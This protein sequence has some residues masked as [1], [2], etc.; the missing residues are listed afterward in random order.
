MV[1]VNS[2]D[3]AF[4]N[5][6]ILRNGG[7]KIGNTTLP[8]V[9]G[10]NPKYDATTNQLITTAAVYALG[11]ANTVKSAVN[12]TEYSYSG[13]TDGLVVFWLNGQGDVNAVTELDTGGS[14]SGDFRAVTVNGKI[15]NISYFLVSDFRLLP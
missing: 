4:D 14:V 1:G 13:E 15:I 11:T 7:F 12:G 2:T 5:A 10:N 6:N 3:V 8:A 9:V